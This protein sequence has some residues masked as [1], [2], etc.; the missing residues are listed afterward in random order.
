[1]QFTQKN[2]PIQITTP[3]GE[4]VML[5]Y[6]LT[7]VE[8]LSEPFEYQLELLSVSDGIEARKLLG[9]NVTVDV[10]L[11]DDGKRHFNGYV[12]RFGQIGS[13]G[14]L[15]CYRATIRP[16][17]WFLTR[18]ANCRIF[19][20]KTVPD[21]VKQV[22]TDH[23]FSDFK[24][25]LSNSYTP[26][27]YCV[28]YGESDFNF[29]SRLMEEEGI[30]YYF[31]HASGKH[32]L[33]LSDSV[34]AHER[35]PGYE[36]IP[37]HQEQGVSDHT[38]VDHIYEW[39]VASEVQSG[40]YALTDYDFKKPRTGLMVKSSV[41][42][43]HYHANYE[44]F[45]YPGEYREVGDGEQLVR[46]R[47]EELQAQYE[48]CDGKGNAR[49]LA[50]GTLFTLDEHP[51][52]SLQREYLV[53]SASYRLQLDEYLPSLQPKEAEKIFECSFRVM[54][55]TVPFRPPR[56]TPRPTVRGPQTAVVVGPSGEEIYVDK[57]ARVKIQFHWDR[58]GDKDEHSSCWVRVSQP[59]AGKNWGMIAHPRIGQEVIVD[60]LEGDPD[61]P[62]I[63][64]RVYNNNQMPPYSLPANATQT[65]I[66]SRSS[67]GGSTANFNEV[68]FEDKIGQEQLYIHA[69]KNQDNVVEH[70]ETT[71]VGRNRS[72]DVGGN[73]TITIHG[74]KAE[75]V[76]MAL[77]ETV[78][79]AKAETIGLG[80][81]LTVGVDYVVTVGK[82]IIITAGDSITLKVG[83]SKM[84]MKK[85][86]SIKIDCKHF[87]ITGLHKVNIF[88]KDIDLN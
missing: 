61:Q 25:Y 57:Y 55:R 77:A 1:M 28:Q 21:I 46:T 54:D 7:G 38:R 48:Y 69:E 43:Q 33:V 35:V 39:E 53:V 16:W 80:K 67:K 50:V 74:F 34:S 49:G 72:E 88:S 84:V 82:D 20:N 17:L 75:T 29:V 66:K 76:I 52:E 22:F 62:I 41:V 51:R 86:G 87:Q 26:R 64:G 68:R 31:S 27:E 37:F 12:T 71:H 85:D 23:G 2:R 19:Q 6:R 73:E 9:E 59:W 58:Y 4:D 44:W 45:H 5:F 79:L 32:D 83:D 60:F 36:K 8:R 30:Y 47:I 13:K 3:L 14:V 63:T 42:R 81:A 15:A 11:P 40:F 56:I 18:A 24:E 65:G 10:A 78:G 70:D